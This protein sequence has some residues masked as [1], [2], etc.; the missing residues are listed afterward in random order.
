MKRTLERELKVPEVA[1]REAFGTSPA[2][3]YWR[4]V[5]L[6]LLLSGK[7]A[8]EVESRTYALFLVGAC[9]LG[10]ALGENSSR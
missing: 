5:L 10:L 4:V 2:R 1:E 6:S 3:R 7:P 8:A 9:Q